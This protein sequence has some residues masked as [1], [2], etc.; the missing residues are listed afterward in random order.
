MCTNCTY[1]RGEGGSM[2]DGSGY[3]E[4]GFLLFLLKDG[5]PIGTK[6]VGFVSNIFIDIPEIESNEYIER[7]VKKKIHDAYKKHKHR[8]ERSIF[9]RLRSDVSLLEEEEEE[10][11]V[12]LEMVSTKGNSIKYDVTIDGVQF[13]TDVYLN[14]TTKDADKTYSKNNVGDIDLDGSVNITDLVRLRKYLAGT[15]QLTDEQKANA[16]LNK[17]GDVNIT[18]LV[19]LRKYLAGS[20]EL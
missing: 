10:Y 6:N 14:I 8:H 1:T 16:D 17:D 20:E 3:T 4:S 11:E 15:E 7:E 13:T 19:K 2:D 18:D 5:E 12:E 9:S